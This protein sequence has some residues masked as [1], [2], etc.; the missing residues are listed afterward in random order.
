MLGSSRFGDNLE[1][2]CKRRA[3]GLFC[4]AITANFVGISQYG[5]AS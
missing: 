3:D 2:Q 5:V 1:S 4:S